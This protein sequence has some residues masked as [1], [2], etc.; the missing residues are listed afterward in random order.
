MYGKWPARRQCADKKKDFHWPSI[1]AA[2]SQN[3]PL[4]EK[5]LQHTASSQANC[6]RQQNWSMICGLKV[7][8]SPVQV[9]RT[10]ISIGRDALYSS[11]SGEAAKLIYGRNGNAVLHQGCYKDLMSKV[12]SRK[13]KLEAKPSAWE[14]RLLRAADETAE[15]HCSDEILAASARRFVA[16]LRAAKHAVVFS[17]AGI[18]TSAGIGDYRGK[19]GKW[20]E[21]DRPAGP[22][23]PEDDEDGVAY[24]ALRPTFTHDSLVWMLENSV[25]KH[26]IT[27]NC[28]GLHLM[29]GMPSENCSELHG[30]VFV[31]VCES[32]GHRYHRSFYVLDDN[33]S[34]LFEDSKHPSDLP[35]HAL[36]CGTCKLSHR[37]GRRCSGSG[38]DPRCRGWLKDSII[39]FGDMLE[40][41]IVARAEKEAKAADLMIGLGSTMA[42]T[43]ACE[44]VTMSGAPLVICNRQRTGHDHLCAEATPDD[45]NSGVPGITSHGASP[46]GLRVFAD[47]DRFFAA[48]MQEFMGGEEAVRKWQQGPSSTLARRRAA[49]DSMRSDGNSS[50]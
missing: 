35:P 43:P 44:L 10:E 23:E 25:I 22:A 3:G 45:D 21:M 2:H 5:P 33:L 15:W 27:Q 1:F 11:A 16:M 41:D 13:R 6:I 31:E 39:N 29:A 19:S 37:T 36:R 46:Q 9:E 42:V 50:Q 26:F 49:Y 7:C 14:C 18:S 34:A 38:G 4:W 48:V 20:T 17:G 28:D 47:T 12:R 30:N 24:E 32:C 8:G 40:D